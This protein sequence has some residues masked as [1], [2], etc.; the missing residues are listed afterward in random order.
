[1]TFSNSN[2]PAKA[3]TK[4]LG[5]VLLIW[6]LLVGGLIGSELSR[7]SVGGL[8]LGLS[9]GLLNK[10]KDELIK[11]L[12]R[13]T[14]VDPDVQNGWTWVNHQ[15]ENS[16][17]FLW[18]LIKDGAIYDKELP[19]RIQRF[20]AMGGTVFIEGSGVSQ[21]VLR[22]LREKVFVDK[23]VK[24]VQKDE[25]LTRTFYILPPAMS[26]RFRTIRQAGR[27]VWIESPMPLLTQLV[28]TSQQ[29]EMSVRACINIVLYALTGSYKDDLTHMRYLMRRRKK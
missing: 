27:V 29:R 12:T 28:S 23:Q 15:L 17:P 10:A 2:W 13:R 22:T 4:A 25:L 6:G 20:I 18:I 1:M 14:Q 24:S 9:G 8:N 19:G 11:E 16:P 7:F 5:L 3:P 26:S 21:E